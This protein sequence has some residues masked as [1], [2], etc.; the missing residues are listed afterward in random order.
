MDVK[1][2][3]VKRKQ[4]LIQSLKKKKMAT[5]EELHNPSLMTSKRLLEVITAES[6]EAQILQLNLIIDMLE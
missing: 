1:K 6:M 4:L 3:L 2:Q 5:H